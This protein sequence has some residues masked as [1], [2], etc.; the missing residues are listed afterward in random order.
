MLDLHDFFAR[1]A[2]LRRPPILAVLTHID[3]LSPAL[4]WS[5]PY[6]W[7]QPH[8]LKEQQIHEAIEAVR[9]QLGSLLDGIIPACT[10]E[11]KVYGVREWLLPALSGVLDQA[12]AVAFLHCINAETDSRKV[13]KIFHQLLSA[14]KG[15]GSALFQAAS[16]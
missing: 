6:N 9:Q 1:R 12:H 14:A 16:K 3:L 11:G 2:D 5:P 13:R 10:A 7:Q 15:L 4:E 8:R